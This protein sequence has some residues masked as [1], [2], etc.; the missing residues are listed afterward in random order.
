MLKPAGNKSQSQLEFLPFDDPRLISTVKVINEELR[1][2]GLV[3]R[4]TMKDDFGESHSA[5]TICSFWLT[6]ALDLIGEEKEALK[7]YEQ[8]RKY[9]NDLDLYSEDIDLKNRKL[10]GNFPQ[11]YTHI[12][13]INTSLLLS[14]WHAIRKKIEV[15]VKKNKRVR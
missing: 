11:A 7:L 5:F 13:L 10:L 8:L 12:A 6:D 2:G 4:Y 9:S 14:E 15:M 3:Q 1:K